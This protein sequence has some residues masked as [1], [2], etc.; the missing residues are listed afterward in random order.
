MVGTFTLC[1]DVSL[2]ADSLLGAAQDLERAGFHLDALTFPIEID[3][4]G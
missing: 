1:I 4:D 3:Q 2:G